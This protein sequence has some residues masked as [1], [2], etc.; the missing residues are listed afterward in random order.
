MLCLSTS[1]LCTY[2]R[3]VKNTVTEARERSSCGTVEKANHTTSPPNLLGVLVNPIEIIGSY[4]LLQVFM[5]REEK[6]IRRKEGSKKSFPQV[7]VALA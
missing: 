3:N 1:F 6:I 7:R 2:A 5:Y 4:V